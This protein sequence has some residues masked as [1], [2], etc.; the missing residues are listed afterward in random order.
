MVIAAD[1]AQCVCQALKDEAREADVWPG[2]DCCVRPGGTAA[3]ELFE[4]CHQAWVILK[5]GYPTTNFPTPDQNTSET[6]CS[7]GIISL[8]AVFEIGVL[9]GV[10]TDA[11]DCDTAEASAASIFGDLQA[12]LRGVNCCFSAAQDDTD[13]GW[14]LNGFDMLGP[15]GG[16]AGVKLDIVVHMNYPCCPVVPVEP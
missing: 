5:N 16:C 4:D 6:H 1:L 14:R 12:V 2:D 3:W 15:Q 10:C 7:K 13:L 9:R 11:C 8:A